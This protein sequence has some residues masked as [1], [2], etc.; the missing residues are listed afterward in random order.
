MAR[1]GLWS[2]QVSET[3]A[4]IDYGAGNLRSAEKAFARAAE[5]T[6]AEIVVTADAGLVARADRIVLPGVGAFADCMAGLEAVPGMI[7]VLEEAVIKSA[8]PFFGICVGMQL[9]ASVGREKIE[10]EGLGWIPGA[11]EKITPADP[12]LKIPH[13]GW[14]TLVLD[15]PHILFDGVETGPDGLHAYFVHSYHFA[16]DDNADR[17]ATA[18]YGGPITAAVGRGN[19][20]GTQFHPEKSQALGLALIGNF[21]RWK[22]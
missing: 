19:V 6:G 2:G 13:M 21:L 12:T 3:V 22:P 10:T 11:V 15:R 17:V 20:F 18:D 9:L 4:I 16:L 5:A 7:E 8:R 14:N 1:K